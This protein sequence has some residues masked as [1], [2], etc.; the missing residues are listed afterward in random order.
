MNHTLSRHARS[1]AF[2]AAA[3]VQPA[4]AQEAAK[5]LPTVSVQADV[6]KPDGY[7]AT[8]TRVGKV[9][10]DPHDIPQAVTTLTG[11]LLEEQQVGSLKEALRNVSGLSFN[12]AEGGRS[13]DNMNLRGFYTF[14]DIYLDGI[15]D[16]AQYN[17]ETFNYE[18]IDVLRGAGAMLFGRGQAGGVINQVSKTPLRIEQYKLTGSVGDYGYREFTADLN[19]PI[20]SD[21]ALRINAMQRDEGSWRSNPASGAEPEIHRKGLALSL[22]LNQRGDHRFWL[23]HYILST[24][25]NPDYG[26]S[27]DGTTKR[28][29]TSSRFSPDTFWGADRTFDKS[30]TR[31]TTLVHE[32]RISA[33]SQL[34]TQLRSADYERSYW[35]RTPSLTVAPS[36]N[37]SLC[38]APA[39][40]NG[41]PTRISDYETV[42]LQS[43]FN[44]KFSALGMKHEVIAGIEYLKENAFRTSLRN[45]G[46]TTTA[47]PPWYEPYDANTT[48]TATRFNSDSY[49]VYA[50]DTV[51]FVPRWKTTLG[52]RRDIMDAKYGS[53]TSPRLTY[54]ENSLR[55]AL[56]FHPAEDTHY[57]L[58]WSDSFSP[59]ADLYQLT[60][61]PQPPERSEVAELG[62]KWLL[63][64][65]DLALR[66]ALYQATKHWERNGD[67]ESTAAILTRKRRTKGIELEAAGRVGERWEIFSGLALMDARILQQAL[68]INATTGAVTV[69]D[70]RYVGQPA[71]NTPPWTINLWATYRLTS[72]WKLGGGLEAKAHRYA[73]SPSGAFPV[74]TGGTT[75]APNTAPA[76]ARWDAMASYEAKDWALRLN[77]KNVFDRLY[78]D[79]VY[80]NGGFAIPGPRR[81]IILTGEFKF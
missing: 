79:A 39:T 10:Q 42:T 36:A 35:A 48:A 34:R 31:I 68:N 19:K 12:S 70:G 61:T 4:L 20:N 62:A 49:A 21:T 6:D 30:D 16:T 75:F 54:G 53:T 45:R 7:R 51:E 24:N 59:T 55:A 77:V 72:Q 1:L 29:G 47:N 40:C 17:R 27:F 78:W 74:V 65:G 58:G 28:P 33:D 64:E 5:E 66:A 25:D 22:A 60:V 23:N 71:R 26:I 8:A 11:A 14:G 81:T 52:L 46:G 15:R 43:D 73:Y 67:L 38:T 13:G 32:Y 50:Q 41:G 76:Y 63:F 56:S 80:D 44:T 57:Y 37:G 18:Q 3:A 9:L 2:A 69:A